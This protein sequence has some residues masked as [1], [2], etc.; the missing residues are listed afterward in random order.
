[1]NVLSNYIGDLHQNLR[2][3]HISANKGYMS[4]QRSNWGKMIYYESNIL[5]IMNIFFG[6]TC[7]YLFCIHLVNYK[8][9][10]ICK[11]VF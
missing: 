3:T 7:T 1:M 5:I 10:K 6:W 4:L 11:A 9:N 2:E 8:L